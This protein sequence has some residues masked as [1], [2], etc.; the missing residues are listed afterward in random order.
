M[1]ER[2]TEGARRTV[3]FAR[4]E[5]SNFSSAYIE[6]EHLLL[7]LLREDKALIRRLSPS[8][9]YDSVQKEVAAHTNVEKESTMRSSAGSDLPLSN[10]SKRV[11]LYSAE[12]ADRLNHRHIG[13]QHLLL[14]LLREKKFPSARLLTQHGAHLDSLR[15][16]VEALGEQ[17]GL[18]KARSPSTY[19]RTVTGPEVIAIRGTKRN[20]EE[21]HREVS[22]LRECY[23]K[24]KRWKARDVVM[25]K[26]GKKLS[27]D[28]TLAKKSSE[29]ELLKGGW[30]KDQCA[31]CRW[32]LFESENVDHGTGFTNGKDWICTECH[33]RFIDN[34]FFSSTY[35]DIT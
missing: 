18:V 33:A 25:K 16:R 6:T 35:S 19:H 34:D 27:F 21:L 28:L 2:Y 5:A 14:A 15:K 4:Y 22:K 10:E 17:I 29:F 23:W 30:K 12:E 1:F 26:V 7:G 31:I 9:E 32:E 20:V 3:F 11:L 8:L 13:T 24:R